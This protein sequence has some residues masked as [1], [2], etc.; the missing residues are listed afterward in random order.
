MFAGTASAISTDISPAADQILGPA[1]GNGA[2]GYYIKQ[3]NG[4]VLLGRNDGLVYDPA[5]ALKTLLLAFAIRQAE[6]LSTTVTAYRY[7]D[8]RN[9]LPATDPNLC[10]NPADENP[11]NAENVSLQQVL[12]QMMQ[13]SN[14]RYARAVELRYG[15]NNIQSFA[16]A[17]GMGNTHLYQIFGCGADGGVQ[18]SWTLDDAGRLYEAIS[19]GSAV[20]P[21]SKDTL[22]GLMLTSRGD[23]YT[24]I[25]S[26]EAS[27]LGIPDAAAEFTNSFLM[28]YKGGGY[29]ICYG[30]CGA[31]D[32]VTRD[33]AGLLT[34]PFQS[35]S[36]VVPTDFVWGSF[37]ANNHVSCPSFPC[38]PSDQVGSAVA[39]SLPEIFRPAIRTAL[40]TW[41]SLTLLAADDGIWQSGKLR[42]SASLST[43]YGGKH[44]SG[45]TV[46]FI[47]G[48]RPL[49]S[50]VTNSSGTASC[51]GIPK[52]N[53][54][55]YIAKF[56]GSNG[57]FAATASG[58]FP[59]A[60]V[61]MTVRITRSGKGVIVSK[62]AG[63]NCGKVCFHTFTLKPTG[64][65][66]LKAKLPKGRKVR[67]SGACKGTSLTCTL[68][69]RAQYRV[70]A[71]FK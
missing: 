15:R 6:P 61:R 60:T 25:I 3:A 13:I 9:G 5:S 28:R 49:C 21:A 10:P 63:I 24:N 52:G 53:N 23:F 59:S 32:V 11:A 12:Y 41:A 20:P 4:G 35:A 31:D 45:Q 38:G 16:A 26:S 18:N 1:A 14:N 70:A 17:L 7:P 48:G 44:L 47:V 71:V 36:G 37:I 19:N 39:L 67:W 69:P 62:P 40:Q 54:T 34:L 58:T 30:S 46:Q 65:V 42:V 27:S 68:K 51:S 57:L 33:E 29:D 8:N 22:L 64:T 2:F 66:V 43:S 50:A 55:T 56:S